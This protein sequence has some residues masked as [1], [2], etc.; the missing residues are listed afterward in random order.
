MGFENY[1]AAG[2]FRD[3]DNTLPVDS[4][5]N[6]TG[7]DVDGPYVGAVELS[8]ILAESETVQGCATRQ[9]V[10]YAMGRAPETADA[11]LVQRLTDRFSSTHGDV[12]DL[13]TA[14]V[15]SPEFR[16]VPAAAE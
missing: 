12:R 9:W 7:T 3:V 13:M 10:R 15:T 11:C 6:V 14:I 4:S 16:H 8:E 5:G 2:A 1:D